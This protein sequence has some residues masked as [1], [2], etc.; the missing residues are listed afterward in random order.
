MCNRVRENMNLICQKNSSILSKQSEIIVVFV[1]FT[2]VCI[3]NSFI[4]S[5]SDAIE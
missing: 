3:L 1:V 4:R 2:C 5:D